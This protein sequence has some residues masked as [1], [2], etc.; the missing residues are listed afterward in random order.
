MLRNETTYR[1][2]GLS[3]WRWVAPE[4]ELLHPG[5]QDRLDRDLCRILAGVGL[6]PVNP[7]EAP[8][9]LLRYEAVAGVLIAELVDSQT[10][11]RVWRT[12]LRG[13][14]LLKRPAETVA[15]SSL[16]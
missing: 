5:V 7:G 2:Y 13:D 14:D 3:L 15:P 1:N 16:N 12:D 6:Q 10:N 8:D 4:L 11:T 9:L